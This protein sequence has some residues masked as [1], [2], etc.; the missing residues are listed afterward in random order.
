MAG[1]SCTRNSASCPLADDLAPAI[2]Y[3]EEGFPVTEL[4]AYYWG[5]SV[6][7]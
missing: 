7:I 4:I 3:A 6:P 5:R 2:H 1:P